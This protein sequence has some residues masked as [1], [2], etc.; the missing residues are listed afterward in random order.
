MI[1]P[2]TLL[3]IL[4]SVLI[5]WQQVTRP[6]SPPPTGFLRLDR[7]RASRVAIY[8]NDYGELAHYRTANATLKA[9]APG[10]NRVVFF[11]DSITE[12]WRIDQSFPGQPYIN[13]GVGGQ[14]TSQML[15]RFRQDTIDIHP[16]AVVILAGTNDIGGNTGPITN[17]DIRAN[18]ASMVELARA[19]NVR[20]ILSSI[21]PV[22]NYTPESKELFASRPLARI[23]ALNQW[24]KNYCIENN[25]VYLDYFS[26]MADER[27]LLK[28][29][30][31]DDGLHPNKAGYTV[32]ASLAE[33]AIESL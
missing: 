1:K 4:L 29:D 30:L 20:V 3:I 2:S 31:A 16:A 8:T 28:R 25:V 18:F 12:N 26:A 33:K 11:G 21:L 23:L 14:T 5:L 9:A 17:E 32:M 7:Y 6:S 24:L 27:G 13:R 22:N 15:I 10:E 19:H